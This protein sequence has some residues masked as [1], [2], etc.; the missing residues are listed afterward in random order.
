MVGEA[1]GRDLKEVTGEKK[2]A[3][4]KT[5]AY[6]LKKG[7]ILK[8]RS[9]ATS[10]FQAMKRANWKDNFP[11]LNF[12]VPFKMPY[13]HDMAVFNWGDMVLLGSKSK[14]GKTTISI[15][16]VRRFVDQGYKPYYICLETGSRFIK[17][18]LHLGLRDGDFFW[19]FQGDPTKIELEKNAITIIDWLLIEDKAQTDTILKHFCEQLFKTNG[20]LIIFM[21]LKQSGGW[22]AP[23]MVEQ[24]PALGARY[25]YK[26]DADGTEGAWNI[27][28]MREAKMK[29][30][31]HKVDC[32]YNWDAKTLNRIDEVETK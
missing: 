12:E 4:D 2:E 30:K 25:L 27:D 14:W 13:F 7:Y 11:S 31:T 8:R 28:C 1:T 3:I 26:N 20:F 29:C 10:V 9:G 16:L 5:L 6:L 19:D 23:N 32:V 18:A 21:Q 15:N 22:F 17:T 24:F